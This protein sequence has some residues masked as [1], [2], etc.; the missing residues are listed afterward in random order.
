MSKKKTDKTNQTKSSKALVFPNKPAKAHPCWWT[1]VGITEEQRMNILVQEQLLNNEEVKIRT[2][3]NPD[4]YADLA[5]I[6]AIAFDTAKKVFRGF[7]ITKGIV[8][9]FD[10]KAENVTTLLNSL[11]KGTVVTFEAC[12]GSNRLGRECQRL[13]L[14]P[15]IF[16]ANRVKNVR[17]DTAKSDAADARA[18]YHTLILALTSPKSD[19]YPV[20]VRTEEQQADQELVNLLDRRTKAATAAGNSLLFLCNERGSVPRSITPVNYAFD[21]CA[22]MPEF[23][24]AARL[25]WQQNKEFAEKTKADMSPEEANS[26]FAYLKT[27][28][29]MFYKEE[30]SKLYECGCPVKA[31]SIIMAARTYVK[32]MEEVRLIKDLIRAIGNKDPDCKRLQAIKGV[33]SMVSFAYVASLRPVAKV[34]PNAAAACSFLGTAPLHTGTGGKTKITG[35]PHGKNGSVRR[36][37]YQGALST[38]TRDKK[39]FNSYTYEQLAKGK[40]IRSIACAYCNKITRVAFAMLRDGSEFNFELVNPVTEGHEPKDEAKS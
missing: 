8:Y 12:A 20:V 2:Y 19:I 27:A 11:N 4:H 22:T 3:L 13:G 15:C 18:I 36:V 5:N 29:E 1:N 31:L 23:Q 33:G 26:N 35:V 14:I 16:S 28:N 38:V 34:L 21:Y 10:I 37:V 39:N 24:A 7:A 17:G 6:S 30:P 32:A 9:N 40:H 25:Y